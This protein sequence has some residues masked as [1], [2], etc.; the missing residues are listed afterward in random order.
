[1]ANTWVERT[2]QN[3]LSAACDAFEIHRDADELYENLME[4]GMSAEEADEYVNLMVEGE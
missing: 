4:A 2:N 1:M 3:K